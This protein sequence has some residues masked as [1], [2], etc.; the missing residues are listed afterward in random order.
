[1]SMTASVVS[2]AILEGNL[3]IGL[4]DGSVINCGF[5]QGPP[6]LK[7]DPGPMGTTGDRGTDGNTIHTVAGTPRNDMGRDG[8][9]AIDNINWR[10]YGPKAGGIWGNANDMLPSK[11]NLIVNGRGFEGGAG[12]S[13]GDTGGGGTMQTTMT[14]P[15]SSPTRISGARGLPDTSG[16]KSQADYNVWAY[17]AL[18]SLAAGVSPDVDLSG[19]ATE[20]Y[21]DAADNELSKRITA[22]ENKPDPESPNLSTYATKQDLSTAT[23]ALPYRIETDKVLRSDKQNAFDDHIGEL[24]AGGEIQLVDNLGYFSNIRFLGEHGVT[25]RSDQQGIIVDASGLQDRIKTLEGQVETLLS[26]V[27]PVDYGEVTIEGGNDYQNGQCWLSPEEMGLF[28]CSLSGSQTNSCRYN[29]ELMRGE[30]RFSGS[31]TQSSVSFICQSEAPNTIVL[32]CTV[33]HPSTE[34]TAHGEIT[35]LVQ[36]SD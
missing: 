23:A 31:V 7:G 10:I 25:T 1:M 19:Y 8:D 12:G 33:S 2:A 29:W 15:L 34:E 3:I 11:E 13:G 5:V 6:G 35:I 24:S 9:Y 14:L 17:G 22:V 30:G 26:L 21:V 20:E 28:V 27:P 4:S 36:P 32:R 16:L 18:E